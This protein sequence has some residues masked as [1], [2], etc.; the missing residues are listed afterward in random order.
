MKILYIIPFKLDTNSGVDKK[1][2]SQIKSFKKYGVDIDYLET[3]STTENINYYLNGDYIKSL[4]KYHFYLSDKFDNYRI[5][6]EIKKMKLNYDYVYIRHFSNPLF[7]LILRELFKKNIKILMEIPTYPYIGEMIK[8]SKF[9]KIKIFLDKILKKLFFKKFVYKII[10]FSEDRI[11]FGIDCINIS[12]GI[13]LDRVFL[14]N[15]KNKN[16]NNIVFTIAS[17]FYY[18]HGID[19]FLYSLLEYKKSNIIATN[20]IFNIIGKGQEEKKLKKIVEDN[21]LLQ[22]CVIFQGFKSGKDLDEIYDQTDIAIG[23]LGRHRSGVY[24]MKA[25]KNREYCAKGLPMIF[26][27]NDLDFENVNFLYK[28]PADESLIDID[29]VI[30]WYRNLKVSSSEIREFSKKFSWDIQMKKVI[31]NI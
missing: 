11:L 4:S 24:T 30:N 22:D 13:D 2:I 6:K 5:A 1:I 28:V 23:S 15:E 17:G 12:N 10:T 20:V 18:W 8:N 25:L 16:H 9:P 29:D 31:D 27:E 26:S 7:V 19:R 3:E 14:K 21:P